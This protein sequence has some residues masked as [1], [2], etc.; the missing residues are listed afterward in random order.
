M[1]IKDVKRT[2][3]KFL[4]LLEGNPKLKLEISV[5]VLFKGNNN[6]LQTVV[7][8]EGRNVPAADL[9]DARAKSIEA[10]LNSITKDFKISSNRIQV[11]RGTIKNPD[12]NK[13]V[14]IKLKK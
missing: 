6:N 9:I 14:E 12:R 11:V 8:F 7:R 1:N 13:N 5:N 3:T 10:L 4:S 2:F